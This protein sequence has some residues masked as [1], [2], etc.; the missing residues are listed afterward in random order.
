MTHR[1]MFFVMS[2]TSILG[3]VRIGT[4]GLQLASYCTS[5]QTEQLATDEAVRARA[6]KTIERMGITKIYIE[7]YRGG[8]VVLR[9]HLIFV[10]D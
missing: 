7:V 1:K 2:L 5:R 8:H 4:A 6:L 3:M 9:E 10:R